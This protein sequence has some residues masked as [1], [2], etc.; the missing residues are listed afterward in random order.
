MLTGTGSFATGSS[1]NIEFSF[2]DTDTSYASA[3]KFEVKDASVHGGQIG[4][5]TDGGPS[6]SGGLG[7][8]IRAMTIDPSQ[9]VGIGTSSP[10]GKVHIS[11][12]STQLVLETPNATND[13]DFRF[14]ENGSN[15]WNFRY[16]NSSNALE[17][18]NQTGST[19]LIQLSLKADGNSTFGGNVGIGTTSPA[20]KLDV[21]SSSGGASE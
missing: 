15:K 21:V 1:R 6:S 7:A 20:A 14:R 8:S 3:I 2:S 17:L 11:A 12:T 10:T 16:Q 4:F 9:N 5:F 19:T 13:I 18:I